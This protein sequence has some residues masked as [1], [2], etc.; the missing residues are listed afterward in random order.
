MR[1]LFQ[2]GLCLLHTLEPNPANQKHPEHEPAI[3]AGSFCEF[4]LP[5]QI[6]FL[7]PNFFL[8]GKRRQQRVLSSRDFLLLPC[9]V[10]NL[11]KVLIS[12]DDKASESIFPPLVL[13]LKGSFLPL[14]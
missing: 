3:A 10:G 2:N 12:R 14:L 11:H 8:P 5:F 6:W 9:K 7:R 4:Y 1:P 13:P